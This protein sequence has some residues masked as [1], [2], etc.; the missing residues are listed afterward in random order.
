MAPPLFIILRSSLL[1]SFLAVA[2]TVWGLVMALAPLLQIRLM[3]QTRDSSN[4]S[5][6]WMAILLIGYVLWFSYGITSGALPL[7]IANTVSTLV[8][9]AMIAVILYYRQPSKR[10]VSA[11]ENSQD[12]AA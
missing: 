9:I 1:Y 8:G 2:T 10:A 12:A 11:V 4:V 7:I 6:S 5:L 3:V